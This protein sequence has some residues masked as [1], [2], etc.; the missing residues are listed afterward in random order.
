M[1]ANGTRTQILR[2]TT[3]LVVFL[4][5]FG[6]TTP[7]Q[8]NAGYARYARGV[9]FKLSGTVSGA[10]PDTLKLF[11]YLGWDLQVVAAIPLKK[12]G[13]GDQT[14]G[15]F[16]AEVKVPARGVYALGFSSDNRLDIVLN[17]DN[18]LKL[19]L[20]QPQ[21]GNNPKILV[22][23]ENIQ[24]QEHSRRMRLFQADLQNADNALN[25]AVS[26]PQKAQEVLA[27]RNK[28][29]LAQLS[30]L[31]SVIQKGGLLAKVAKL[32]YYRPYGLDADHKIRFDSEQAYINAA[33]LPESVV[34]DSSYAYVPLVFDK[35]R[36]AIRQHIEG[37]VDF[38]ATVEHFGKLVQLAPKGSRMQLLLLQG[39]VS[40]AAD[41]QSIDLYV[42]FADLFTELFPN[43]PKTAKLKQDVEQF[44]K[45]R[46][47][48][49]APEIE[50][51]GVDGKLV[52]LSSL[53]GKI[54]LIDFWASWC[55]PCRREN[56][57]VVR[58]YNKYKDKGFEIYSYSLDQNKDAWLKAIKDDNLTWPAH[59]SDLAGW[60]S[61]GSGAYGVS[62]IPFTVLLDRKGNV[63]AKGL[64][65]PQLEQKL[66]KLL[67]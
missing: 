59:S 26:N 36:F 4:L 25:Q 35:A 51:P 14:I 3:P 48:K 34:S 50:A 18:T 63:I 15:S 52:K 57:N 39:L 49:P 55:G 32:Q 30:Y 22:G 11:E 46:M 45:I 60:R 43:S 23:L 2:W 47:G 28:Y 21:V 8:G 54:V 29:L 33:F 56:P 64:R 9:A 1:N 67:Q 12:T 19:E 53:R 58:V 41:L 16:E 61:Q 44:G 37:Q 20:K 24:Y 40:G 66:E 10:G 6:C 13:S 62:G 65:G 5:L 42:H 38:D 17:E 31:D 7:T 27:M